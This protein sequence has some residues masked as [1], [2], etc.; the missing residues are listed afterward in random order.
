[1][2]NSNDETFIQRPAK[3]LVVDGGESARALLKRRLS[4]YG[5]EVFTAANLKG[6]LEILSTR[7]MDVIFL[8]MFIDGDNSHDFLISLKENS[9]YRHI[10]VIMISEDNDVELVVK[11]IEAGAEDYLIK[12]LNQT[13]LKAR[14]ANCVARKEARD[15]EIAF[16][17]KIE[18]GQ[19]QIAAQEKMASLGTLLSSISQELK[20]PLNFVINFASVS[21]EICEELLKQTNENKSAVSEEFFSSLCERLRNFQSNVTKISEHG[22]NADKILR[23]MLDQSSV[24]SGKKHPGSINKIISQT[25]VMLLASY[26]NNGITTLPKIETKFDNALPH[27]PVSTQSFSKAIYNILDNAVYSVIHKFE[28]I[29]LA[30]V[31]ITTEDCPPDIKISIYDNGTGIK[32]DIM[33]KIFNPFFT[34]KPEGTG[35]GLGLSTA[36]EVVQEHSGT[37]VVDSQENE[38]AEF[39]LTIGR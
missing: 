34:T 9:R 32:P 1:M 33:E 38:F 21:A 10:P 35:P 4:V 25:I 30:K 17:A 13:L 26:K 8:N 22:Q 3:V 15:K 18:Q 12:P 20:N 11:S 29:T 14:L 37:L 2:E 19:K 36:L 5:H 31:V 24:S 6:A 39:K 28:D 16:L 27:V 7:A 23:F